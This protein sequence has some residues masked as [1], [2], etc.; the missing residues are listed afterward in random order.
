VMRR[1]CWA[2]AAVAIIS[3]PIDSF[4]DASMSRHMLLQIPLLVGMGYA[5]VWLWPAARLRSPSMRVSAIIFAMGSLL[6]W[7]LPRSLDTAVTVTWVDQ[8]MH[9]NMLLVGWFLAISLPRLPFLV[10]MALGV[11]GL[12]MAL[13]AG[14]VY[15]STTI[16]V[17]STY[18]VQQQNEAGALL[19]WIGSALFVVLLGRGAF[20]LTAIAAEKPEQ[21]LNRRRGYFEFGA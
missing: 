16:P 5:A 6:F 17:C 12:A 1:L 11:Y 20:L 9:A 18:S 10:K 8:A 13:A 21:S 14:V 4:L 15:A 7:M 2:A 19:L 3:P